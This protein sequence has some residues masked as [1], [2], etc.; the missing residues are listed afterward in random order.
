MAFLVRSCLVAA[1]FGSLALAQ[2]Q[3]WAYR[4]LQR[5]AV[6]MPGFAVGSLGSGL[7]SARMAD[8]SPEQQ[9]FLTLGFFRTCLFK[10]LM[11]LFLRISYLGTV[12]NH[13]HPSSFPSNS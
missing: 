13:L 3:W 12:F 4:P 11:F 6:P 5:P 9:S 2:T 7:R 1:T 8:F 10:N